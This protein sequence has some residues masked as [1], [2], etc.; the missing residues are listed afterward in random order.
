M[1]KPRWDLFDHLSAFAL[2]SLPDFPRRNLVEKAAACEAAG[3]LRSI[4]IRG[5]S[6]DM[7]RE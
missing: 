6:L 1:G 2:Q 4:W 3:K 7:Q 5:S